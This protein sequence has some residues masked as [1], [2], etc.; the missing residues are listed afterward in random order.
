QDNHDVKILDLEALRDVIEKHIVDI[1]EFAPD[2]IGVFGTSP[3]HK[4]IKE[5]IRV[6][7]E[8]CPLSTIIV[9]GPHATFFPEDLLN[10]EVKIDYVFRGEAENS[11]LE[12]VNQLKLYNK[13]VDQDKIPGIAY[14]IEKDCFVDSNIPRIKDLD[15][16]PMPA[17]NLL[18]L[19][20]YFEA[21]SSEKTITMMTSRGCPN[22]CIYCA[23]PVLYG[24]KFRSRSAAN[25]VDEMRYLRDQYKID[26]VVF[27]DST[28]NHDKDRV[29]Q[30]CKQIIKESIGITWRARV[31]ADKL[32]Q[33]MVELMKLSGCEEL[34]LGVETG[35]ERILTILKKNE[36]KEEIKNA[37]E[38]IREQNLWCSGY[39]MFGIPGETVSDM[40]E[41]IDFAIE[42]NPDWALFSAA[43]PFP[44]TEL[45]DM[46]E[47]DLINTD[48]GNYKFNFNK[49]IISYDK[50]S[51]EQI[52][53]YI[54]LAYEKF[55][56]RKEWLINRLQKAEHTK[57]VDNIIN[58][59]N[60]YNERKKSLPSP[61]AYLQ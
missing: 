41:T 15:S 48:L 52:D 6:L 13:V 37:F 34:S 18:P 22:Q 1:K 7:N 5:S 36:T 19:E 59:Y 46:V 33:E 3:I 16:V 8:I 61:P 32:D 42:L 27:Y 60:F 26:H 58:S 50:I 49:S 44:G 25:V 38:L 21:G 29:K 10:S 23:E 35:S 28:F 20:R 12:F 55:Y 2:I 56:L 17:Y 51:N 14:K 31:R 47:K 11:I 53:Y 57:Q 40:Q 9:G 54:N 43:T 30:I 24:K 39:F 4:Y 45:F